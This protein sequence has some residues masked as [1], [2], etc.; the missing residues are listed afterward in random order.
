MTKENLIC[1]K[2]GGNARRG[3]LSERSDRASFI[4]KW[5][6]GEPVRP[7]FLG[8]KGDNVDV[9]NRNAFDV[10]SLRCDRCGFLELYAV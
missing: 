3:F 6:E 1:S 8:I 9:T 5:I 7:Q 4:P 10:R 2:C